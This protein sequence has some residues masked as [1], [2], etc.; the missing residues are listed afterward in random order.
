MNEIFKTTIDKLNSDY[1]NFGIFTYRKFTT[2]AF[3]SQCKYVVM[4]YRI[5]TKNLREINKE[6][7]GDL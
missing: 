5:P 4:R 3:K 1:Y 7:N 6:V 2:K